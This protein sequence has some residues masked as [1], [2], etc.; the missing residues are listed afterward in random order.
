MQQFYVKI[1]KYFNCV[2]TYFVSNGYHV[3]KMYNHTFPPR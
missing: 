1:L 2:L 3:Y